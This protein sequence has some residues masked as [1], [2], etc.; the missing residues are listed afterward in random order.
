MQPRYLT[1]TL[2]V[3]GQLEIGDIAALVAQGYRGIINNRPDCE[4][5]DQPTSAELEAVARQSSLEY[6]Y[7]PV[8]PGQVHAS[9][10][11]AFAMAL[12]QMPKPV[13][14][15]CRT[16]TRAASLWAISAARHADVAEVLGAVAAAGY[17]LDP[18]RPQLQQLH[19]ESI[20]GAP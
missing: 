6:R 20:R 1:P 15:F 13:V 9:Q 8:T 5:K 17:P 11:Q 10:V 14:A 7:I 12:E 3:S 18:L 16:G 2:S 19:D 4:T